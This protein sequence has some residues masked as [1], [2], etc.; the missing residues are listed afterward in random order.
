MLQHP[1]V[2]LFQ[3]FA[4]QT[5]VGP[6]APCDVPP[7]LGTKGFSESKPAHRAGKGDLYSRCSDCRV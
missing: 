2:A 4:K 1:Y 5:S 6:G 7:E 3:K